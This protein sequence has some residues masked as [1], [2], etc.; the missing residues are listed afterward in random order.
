[1]KQPKWITHI[2]AIDHVAA[3]YWV[4]RGWSSEAR[5]Q[6]ISIIDTV[7]QDHMEQGRIPIGG[8]AWAGDRG[9]RQVEVQVDEG[10]WT[11]AVLRTPPL[12]PLT[13][14]QWRYDWPATRGKHTF[15]VRA[16]DGTGALQIEQEHMPRPE[17]ATGYV[18]VTVTIS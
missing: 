14:V 12:G 3:G 10:A 17:G 11:E 4:H 15:R 18:S 5:P 2:E 7:S 9:I 16:T 1:M 8:I 6:I 13:W